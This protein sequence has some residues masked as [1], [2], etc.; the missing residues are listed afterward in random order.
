MTAKDGKAE[1]IRK[2]PQSIQVFIEE[3][4]ENGYAVGHS[5]G[6]QACKRRNYERR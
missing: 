4:W 2:A 1:L 6:Y 3:A 5:N